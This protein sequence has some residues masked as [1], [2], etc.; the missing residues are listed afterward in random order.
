MRSLDDFLQILVT[1]KTN[2][3]VAFGDFNTH[4][5]TF[6]ISIDT[7]VVETWV[8]Y[9]DN[10]ITVDFLKNGVVKEE[11]I[12]NIWIQASTFGPRFPRFDFSKMSLEIIPVDRNLFTDR[13]LKYTRL[14]YFGPNI[15]LEKDIPFGSSDD[16]ILELKQDIF[17]EN[18]PSKN[19]VKYPTADYE[20]YN[21]C[22]KDFTL[23][24]LA[25]Y[26]GPS[27]V[28][29]WATL[30]FNNVT[31]HHYIDWSYDYG[32]LFDGTTKSNCPL[33]C[34]TTSVN[35]RFISRKKVNKY[36]TTSFNENYG[37]IWVGGGCSKRF[38]CFTLHDW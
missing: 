16:Y 19:C 36:I 18:D 9:F 22:D 33:P 28:P 27:L 23:K 38:L 15:V 12:L 5:V 24:T 3:I 6:N 8:N 11:G 34:T 2:N 4:F 26:Y 20:T 1:T 30:D 37:K 13:N 21:D 25:E 17:V 14:Y 29:I 31:R 32:Y 7:I 10:C 35:A